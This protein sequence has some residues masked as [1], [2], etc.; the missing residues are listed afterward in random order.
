MGQWG[1][2]AAVA[3]GGEEWGPE[4]KL[5]Q[6]HCAKACTCLAFIERKAADVK[7]APCTAVTYTQGTCILYM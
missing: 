1:G 5:A 6:S 4:Q 7:H 3:R 2:R